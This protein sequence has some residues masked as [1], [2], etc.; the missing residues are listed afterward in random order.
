MMLVLRTQY[1]ENYGTAEDPYWKNKGGQE[2]KVKNIPT[3]LTEE[4]LL[5]VVDNLLPEVQYENEYQIQYLLD[6][7]IEPDDYLSWF[8]RSQLEYD[9]EITYKEPELKYVENV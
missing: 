4:E 7:S 6:W 8:E 2:F 1:Q 3:D 9:G 5:E